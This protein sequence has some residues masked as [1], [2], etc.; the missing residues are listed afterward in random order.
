MVGAGALFGEGVVFGVGDND[1]VEEED[2]KG[3]AGGG[4][5]CVGYLDLVVD[6][7][8]RRR[9]EDGMSYIGTNLASI[10][11]SSSNSSLGIESS[12]R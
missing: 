3:F 8:D 9:T 10:S 5:G 1:V 12:V 11:K 4:E 7:S 6:S 2:V